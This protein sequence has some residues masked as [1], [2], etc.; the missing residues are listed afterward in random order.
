[1]RR[2]RSRPCRR[3]S[4]RALPARPTGPCSTSATAPSPIAS[5]PKRS[6]VSPRRSSPA[7]L[8]RARPSGCTCRTRP[9]HPIAFFACM[10]AGIRAVHMSAL[11]AERELA[12]K[13]KDFFGA[14]VLVTTNWAALLPKAEKLKESGLVDLLLVG[15]DAAWVRGRS[16]SRRCRAATASRRSPTSSA[17]PTAPSRRRASAST[18]SRCCNTPAAPPACRRARC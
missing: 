7:A 6:T 17:M 9:Y 14:R 2:S 1:M 11:E 13:L 16:R 3:C 10:K 18:T 12:H 15:D 5:S 4:M 8:G